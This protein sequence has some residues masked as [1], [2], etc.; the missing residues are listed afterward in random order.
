MMASACPTVFWT[1]ARSRSG[2]VD[3]VEP[4]WFVAVAGDFDTEVARAWIEDLF[5]D[6]DVGPEN[7]R[8]E[9]EGGLLGRTLR[10]VV[11]DDV[12]LPRLSRCYHSP[13]YFMPGDAELDVAAHI[14]A[15]ERTGRLYR[16]LVIEEGVAVDVVDP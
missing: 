14:L 15:N 9:P 16:R 12:Q 4:V 7:P 11:H 1:G 3:L 8:P 10:L 2:V 5:G 13:A 6:L